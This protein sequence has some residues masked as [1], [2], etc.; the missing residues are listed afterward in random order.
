MGGLRNGT[1]GEARTYPRRRKCGRGEKSINQRSIKCY[2]GPASTNGRRAR[3][4]HTLA[5]LDIKVKDMLS[6]YRK[7]IMI[8]HIPQ[9]FVHHEGNKTGKREPFGE[10]AE[11][12]KR[13]FPMRRQPPSIRR[14]FI[15]KFLRRDLRGSLKMPHHFPVGTPSSVI[16]PGKRD[17]WASFAGF[18]QLSFWISWI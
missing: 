17:L 3:K 13:S 18:P 4:A 5:A 10:A 16:P 1:N 9:I 15:R 8:I 11:Q 6:F 2:S 12:W 7:R 14:N